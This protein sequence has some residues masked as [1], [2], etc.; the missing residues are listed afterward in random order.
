MPVVISVLS[1]RG[2]QRLDLVEAVV[3]NSDGVP[4]RYSE[5]HGYA[6]DPAIREIAQVRSSVPTGAAIAQRFGLPWANV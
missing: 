2:F 3:R 1:Q 6:V 5:L 4:F